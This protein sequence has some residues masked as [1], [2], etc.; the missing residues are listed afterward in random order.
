MDLHD[1]YV[2]GVGFDS[3]GVDMNDS[4]LSDIVKTVQVLEDK[5]LYAH[6]YLKL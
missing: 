4:K 1:A 2:A 3:S 6:G 5:T